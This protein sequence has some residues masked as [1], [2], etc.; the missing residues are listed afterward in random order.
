MDN[1][2]QFPT[3]ESAGEETVTVRDALC[4]CIRYTAENG[5]ID[6]RG[7]QQLLNAINSAWNLWE[8]LTEK[9]E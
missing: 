5:G 8:H 3:R 7:E 4:Y 2:I 6:S 9:E 1:V